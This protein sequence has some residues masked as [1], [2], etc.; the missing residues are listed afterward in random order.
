MAREIK[1]DIGSAKKWVLR[2]RA[3]GVEKL[4]RRGRSSILKKHLAENPG[5]FATYLISGDLV[6]EEPSSAGARNGNADGDGDIDMDSSVPGTQTDTHSDD[7]ADG[8]GDKD[9]MTQPEITGLRMLKPV[10]DERVRRRGMFLVGADQVEGASHSYGGRKGDVLMGRVC[11][12][13]EDVRA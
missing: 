4:K 10:V 13:E 12:E 5:V 11:R 7:G 2:S 8:A 6:D 1:C 3:R 9:R